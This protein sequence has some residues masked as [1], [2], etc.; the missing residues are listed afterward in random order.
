MVITTVE[1]VIVVPKPLSI[2]QQETKHWRVTYLQKA[3]NA[4][5]WNWPG[6][7]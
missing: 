2:V 7:V 4:R 6:N 1:S 5:H 3:W